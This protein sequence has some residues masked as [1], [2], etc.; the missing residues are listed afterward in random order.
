LETENNSN[1]K[2][3]TFLPILFLLI[4]MG[5]S[6]HKTAQNL[7][8]GKITY[9]DNN[10]KNYEN[11]IVINNAENVKQGRKAEIH[12]LTEAYGKQGSDWVMFSKGH[13]QLDGKEY[14]VI[15]IAIKGSKKTV[16]VYFDVTDFWEKY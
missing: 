13:K 10:G 4:L 3:I 15:E 7:N 2:K 5:C 6:T 11:A 14:D 16:I 12:Y 8:F 9:S 1:M